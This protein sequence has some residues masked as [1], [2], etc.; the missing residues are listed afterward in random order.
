MPSL[1]IPLAFPAPLDATDLPVHGPAD[2]L[3]VLPDDHDR[4]DPVE[5]PVFHGLV[6]A[7]AE[8]FL[9]Y[10]A[11]ASYAAAQSDPSRATGI[12]LAEFGRDVHVLWQRDVESAEGF[13]DRLFGRFKGAAPEVIKAAV[14]AFLM[15]YTAARCELFEPLSDRLYLF[16]AAGPGHALVGDGMADIAPAYPWRRYDLRGRVSP[17]GALLFTDSYPRSFWLRV[18][19]LA[20]AEELAACLTAAASQD[21]PESGLYVDDGADELA[22]AFLFDARQTADAVYAAIIHAVDLLA[23]HGVSWTLLIDP[24]LNANA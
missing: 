7:E 13:R 21:D 4:A 14:D 23:G 10:Q 2:V 16:D 20:G 8:L 19:D 24:K 6:E 17:G 22:G 12:Y 5:A 18:P 3:A 1:P 9:A 15:P 11:R